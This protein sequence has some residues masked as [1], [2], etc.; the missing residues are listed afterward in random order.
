M[1]LDPDNARQDRPDKEELLQRV[2]DGLIQL[3]RSKKRRMRVARWLCVA[4]VLLLAAAA[5]A[6]VWAY[7]RGFD[8]QELLK[9]LRELSGITGAG[10]G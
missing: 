4:A 6:V 3:D 5:G 7:F 2:T 1:S 8:W 9:R 10:S